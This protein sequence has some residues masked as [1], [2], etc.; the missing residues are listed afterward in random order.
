MSGFPGESF[1]QFEQ[2]L[3]I[4]MKLWKTH[5]LITVNG[6]FPF[7]AYPRTE[8]FHTAVELGLKTPE[9]LDEWGTWKFQYE[10]D[11]PWLDDTMKQWM[12]ISFFI[13]RFRYYLA[14]LEDRHKN[15]LRVKLLRFVLLPLRVSAHIR[16]SKRW[17]GFAWEWRLFALMVR[18]TFG[19]M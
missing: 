17:F 2:T 4:I 9:T 11:N 15:S 7:N 16:L 14:R 12:Q 5:P 10:P 6:I 1:E 8:L 3:D 19:Y 13:V 18:K